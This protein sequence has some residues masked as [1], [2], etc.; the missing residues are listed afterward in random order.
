MN[1]KAEEKINNSKKTREDLESFAQQEEKEQKI[2]EKENS[3]KVSEQKSVENE[4][5]ANLKKEIEVLK[6]KN[7]RLL[8][9]LDNQR[10]THVKE[11][12]KVV[13]Y[14]CERLLEQF[15]SFPDNCER[16]IQ[17][18][19]NYQD[20][21]IKNFLAGFQMIFTEFQN[22]LKNQGAEEIKVSPQKDVYNRKIHYAVEVE[23]NNDYPE[24]TV[25]QVFR[26]GYLYHQE[27]LRPAEVKISKRGGEKSRQT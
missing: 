6:D 14:N 9:D 18:S 5:F 8:A 27:V 2:S 26:K 25:L 20:P 12:E 22:T 13:K 4:K 17:A 10:R 1:K 23:E 21:K 7:L 3:Q 19:Q 16:A 11:I 15:L 24:G